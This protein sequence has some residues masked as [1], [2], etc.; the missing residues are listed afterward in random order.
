MM[1]P[2]SCRFLLKVHFLYCFS[3]GKPRWYFV[4]NNPAVTFRTWKSK[5]FS[6]K[7]WYRHRYFFSLILRARVNYFSRRN[8][9]KGLDQLIARKAEE[10]TCESS[11]D[12]GFCR[13][14]LCF[15]NVGV[16]NLSTH[17]CTGVHWRVPWHPDMLFYLRKKK[18]FRYIFAFGLTI[19]NWLLQFMLIT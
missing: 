17:T 9:G 15:F 4:T 6:K 1:Y 19:Q 14:G 7:Q 3:R 10:F 16:A 18:T 11:L 2:I 12:T 8:A 13:W 5:N